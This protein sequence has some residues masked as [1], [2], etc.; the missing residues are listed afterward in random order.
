[1]IEPINLSKL[2]V[3]THN[4]II[5]KYKKNNGSIKYYSPQLRYS[6]LY[7]FVY[8]ECYW[9]RHCIDNS[10]INE[11]KNENKEH[12]PNHIPGK[13]LN[14]I[15]LFYVKRN[16]YNSLYSK[17]VNIWL[18]L[19]N[20]STLST[21]SQD[22]AF[23]RNLIGIGCKRNP[24]YYNKPGYKV[25][26]ITDSK[27][28]PI[29]MA[30]TNCTDHDSNFV[31]LLLKNKII[32]DAIFNNN[33]KTFLADS[34]YSTLSNLYDLSNSGINVIMGR[35]KQHITKCTAV[36]DISK[37]HKETYGGRCIVEN[38]F[39]NIERYP[40]L[41]NNYEKTPESYAGLLTFVLC[42]ILTN[43]I[44]T[45]ISENQDNC[46]KE[47]HA[48]DLLKSQNEALKRKQAKYDERKKEEKLKEL[49][50]E[51]RKIYNA[52]LLEKINNNIQKYIDQNLIKNAYDNRIKHIKNIANKFSFEKYRNKANIHIIEHFRHNA[53]TN[54]EQFKFA[55]KMAFVVSV[56]KYAFRDDT[57][58]DKMLN[59]SLDKI[60]EQLNIFTSIFFGSN[61]EAA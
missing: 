61:D 26:V 9:S 25:H 43:K 44:N 31:T 19:T 28:V 6:E 55:K 60:H 14:A 11:R 59:Y 1:M 45:L 17:L 54:T 33:V 41:I 24:Q 23:I 5:S 51:K 16:L 48:V 15:H 52:Q 50:S 40:C 3:Q 36:N 4:E 38:F 8:K 13:Y 49:E 29:S 56:E 21:V 58:R 27:R 20:Y 46:I 39:A 35:N 53:L 34:A 12:I 18:Q 2:F 30:V 47:R 10:I 22:S 7:N 37:E 42:I 32:N 57:I